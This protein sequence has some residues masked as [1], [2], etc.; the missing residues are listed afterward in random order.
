M[1]LPV[2]RMGHDGLGEPFPIARGQDRSAAVI[3]DQARG[4]TAGGPQQYA[5]PASGKR[6]RDLAWDQHSLGTLIH[7]C[8]MEIG[9]AK[10]FRQVFLRLP[11]QLAQVRK[12]TILDFPPDTA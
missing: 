4:G 5:G 10:A 3:G 11:W 8:K 1:E 6:T 7:G 2:R 9:G 12:G